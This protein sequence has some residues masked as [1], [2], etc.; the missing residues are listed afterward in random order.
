MSDNYTQYVIKVWRNYPDT[1]SPIDEDNLDHIEQGIKALETEAF[2]RTDLLTAKANASVGNYFSVEDEDDPLIK[3][4]SFDRSTGTFTIYYNDGTSYTI[5][6]DLEKIAVNFDYDDDPTS[7][8]YQ[9]LILTL[10]DGTVKYID[11]SALITQYEFANTSSVTFNVDTTTGAVTA[12][13]PTNAITTAMIQNG[14]VTDAKLESGYLAQVTAQA[15]IA[16]NSRKDSEAWAVGTKDGQPVPNTDPQYNNYSEY[17]ANQA[18]TDATNIQNTWSS[19]QYREVSV[20]SSD[21]EINYNPASKDDYPYICHKLV[22]DVLPLRPEW[23]M[24]STN[25]VPIGNEIKAISFVL[26]AFFGV[27]DNYYTDATTYTPTTDKTIMLYATTQPT[28]NLKLMYKG[29]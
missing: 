19:M 27:G 12:T 6:T 11:L 10:I 23:R 4:I 20:A 3:P 26:E 2:A 25:V 16:T 14:A 18:H 5:D 29:V 8:H 21:W 22:T 13:I 15:T 1:S 28:V 9:C 24:A 17:W 7:A